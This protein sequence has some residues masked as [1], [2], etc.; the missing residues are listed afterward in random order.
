MTTIASAKTDTIINEGMPAYFN[1]VL[2]P[3]SNYRHYVGGIQKL[4]LLQ[5]ENKELI[6]RPSKNW[7]LWF[8]LGVVLGFIVGQSL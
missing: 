1:G 2:V 5:K 8:P 7:I 3:E 6:E 4:E